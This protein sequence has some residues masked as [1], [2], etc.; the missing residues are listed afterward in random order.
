[1]FT[2]FA[3]RPSRNEGRMIKFN[4]LIT[5]IQ[6]AANQAMHAVSLKNMDLLSSYFDQAP[7]SADEVKD[8]VNHLTPKLVRISFPQ[9]T[10]DGPKT[11]D[12]YVPLIS[13]SPISNIQMCEM[14]VEMDLELFE[15]DDD[16]L[17]INFPSEH[18]SLFGRETITHP[19]PN[20]KVKI[21]ISGGD[22]PSGVSAIIEGYNRALKGQ[23]P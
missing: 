11:H 13:I 10:S 9:Q 18:K 22:R 15:D 17:K 4:Q 14:E 19:T 2:A 8:S 20:A 16:N 23:I 21:K 3:A 7:E 12:V 1:M 6:E 5:A